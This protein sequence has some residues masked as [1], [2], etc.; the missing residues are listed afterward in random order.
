MRCNGRGHQQFYCRVPNVA[1]ACFRCGVSGHFHFVCPELWRQYHQS[2]KHEDEDDPYVFNA[3]NE[4]M[5]EP[6][7]NINKTPRPSCFNCGRRG[8]HG[9]LCET[10]YFRRDVQPY[11]P[12]VVKYDAAVY[13]RPKTPLSCPDFGATK[14]ISA[15]KGR[16]IR[17]NEGGDDSLRVTLNFDEEENQSGHPQMEEFQK[18]G[19]QQ[20]RE[21]WDGGSVSF[22][23]GMGHRAA[24]DSK[25]K[26]KRKAEKKKKRQL[27]REQLNYHDKLKRQEDSIPERESKLRAVEG[28]HGETLKLLKEKEKAT[29]E[30][31][32]HLNQSMRFD[33]GL[34]NDVDFIA[35]SVGKVRTKK[36]RKR[37]KLGGDESVVEASMDEDRAEAANVS[38]VLDPSTREKAARE[39]ARI[40]ERPTNL[41]GE[42]VG[43]PEEKKKRREK[44]NAEEYANE[45]EVEIVEPPKEKKKRKEKKNAEEHGNEDEVE[46]VEPPKEKKKRKEKQTSE[47]HANEVEIVGEVKGL[48]RSTKES[49]LR[50]SERKKPEGTAVEVE[51]TKDE[52]TKDTAVEGSS[53]KKIR[54]RR[55]FEDETAKVIDMSKEKNVSKTDLKLLSPIRAPSGTKTKLKKVSSTITCAPS[56]EPLSFAIPNKPDPSMREKAARELARIRERTMPEQEQEAELAASTPESSSKMRTLS[57]RVEPILST[58]TQSKISTSTSTQ[59][60]PFKSMP[61]LGA[62]IEGAGNVKVDTL[63]RRQMKKIRKKKE[64]KVRTLEELEQKDRQPSPIDASPLTVTISNHRKAKQTKKAEES[65]SGGGEELCNTKAKG[66]KEKARDNKM[67][68]KD[69][70]MAAKDNKMA[71]KDIKKDPAKAIEKGTRKIFSRSFADHLALQEAQGSSQK[72]H[73]FSLD[74]DNF[75]RK[76]KAKTQKGQLKFYE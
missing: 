43:P 71:A 70:K 76:K 40:R 16:K 1:G 55:A 4:L 73:T 34:I 10:D 74:E 32:A 50:R 12:F 42:Q 37:R 56:N 38:V 41:T 53:K 49:I 29:A 46:I 21:Q 63:S 69:N 44:K 22:S 36:K 19:E 11:S 20:E 59:Y 47:E 68:A 60:T 2:V 66:N 62:G 30:K 5:E 28:I 15:A 17:F 9:H 75:P 7:N 25:W 6:N 64:R 51:F 26:L 65:T 3:E 72:I 61:A 18:W 35:S 54:N 27:K 8:H 31:I 23:E 45:D 52:T 24:K 48:N 58:P 57:T 33:E 39:L 67:A 14:S 13:R